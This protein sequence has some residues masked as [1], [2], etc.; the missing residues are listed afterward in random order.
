MD[1]NT[2]AYTAGLF[3]GEGC[4]VI[5]RGPKKNGRGKVYN[6][7]MIRMEICNTDFDLITSIQKEWDEG[8]ICKIPPRK[9]KNGMSKPQLRWQLTHRQA[10]R[11]LA[12]IMPYMREQNKLNKANEIIEYYRKF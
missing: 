8:H 1:K 12:K 11:V 7:V 10:H 2:I 5:T 9:V 4:I 6:C 3:D